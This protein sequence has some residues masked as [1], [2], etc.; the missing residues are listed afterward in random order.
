MFLLLT[1]CVEL[2]VIVEIIAIAF[3]NFI[4]P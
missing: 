3:I 1:K 4:E 2:T